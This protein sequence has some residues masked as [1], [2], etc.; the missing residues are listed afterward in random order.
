V[1]VRGFAEMELGLLEWSV[2][3]Y[4]FKTSKASNSTKMELM[5]LMKQRWKV[6]DVHS[7]DVAGRSVNIVFV[8]LAD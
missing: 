5:E 7:E 3:L 8:D 4:A 6:T 1:I 2:Y